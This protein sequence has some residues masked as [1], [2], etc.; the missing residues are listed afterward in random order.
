MRHRDTVAAATPRRSQGAAAAQLREQQQQ[1]HQDGYRPPPHVIGHRTLRHLGPSGS[2]A[3][4][5]R[6]RAPFTA[7][8]SYSARLRVG[9]VK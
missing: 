4:Q 5:S 6:G 7:C 8:Q 3:G 2:P 9:K 1:E